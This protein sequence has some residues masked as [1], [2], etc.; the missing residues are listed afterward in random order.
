MMPEKTHIREEPKTPQIKTSE[1]EL[2][3]IYLTPL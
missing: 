3:T 1:E 2:A